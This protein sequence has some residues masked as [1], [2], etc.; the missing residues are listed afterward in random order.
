MVLEAFAVCLGSIPNGDSRLRCFKQPSQRCKFKTDWHDVALC[1][2]PDVAAGSIHTRWVLHLAGLLQQ[3]TFGVQFLL[4]F[5]DNTS[6]N[7]AER[8]K[9]QQ[10]NDA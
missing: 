7:E 6:P 5:Y 3:T 4:A 1:S 10:V 9:L 8:P 2:C